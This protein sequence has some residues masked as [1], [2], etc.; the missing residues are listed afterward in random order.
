MEIIQAFKTPALQ[1]SETAPLWRYMKLTTFFS[2]LHGTVFIP[3]LRTLRNNDPKEGLIPWEFPIA[4]PNAFVVANDA[5]L[6]PAASWLDEKVKIA[7]ELDPGDFRIDSSLWGVTS[8]R[9]E[10]WHRE[11][12]K[13]RAIWCWHKS[14]HESMAMW[15]I[16]AHQGVAIRTDLASIRRSLGLSEDWQA[17]VGVLAY[18]TP[19][20][21]NRDD[22]EPA[23]ETAMC[24]KRPFMFKSIDYRHE[25]EVRL[26]LKLDSRFGAGVPRVPVDPTLLIKEVR[27]SP[28]IGDHEQW[29]L[30][31]ILQK[32]VDGASILVEPSDGLR[33]DCDRSDAGEKFMDNMVAPCRVLHNSIRS[34]LKHSKL[35]DSLS[36]LPFTEETDIPDLLNSL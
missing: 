17:L 5:L 27:V 34:V 26:I 32:V 25:E 10:I 31:N 23:E 4:E 29:V 28:F 19:H 1:V 2:L 18:K 21:Y 30:V 16:Y 12:A 15:N 13:R 8:S 6:E 33:R 11:L 20:W 24:L 36:T 9:L 7:R 3:S 14:E 22:F 35:N